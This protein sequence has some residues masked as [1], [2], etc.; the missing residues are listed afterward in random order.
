VAA[1]EALGPSGRYLQAGRLRQ[2]VHHG[3]SSPHVV[4]VLASGKLGNSELAVFVHHT[5]LGAG[6]A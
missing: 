5:G 4:L 3:L 6:P 1:V 2:L